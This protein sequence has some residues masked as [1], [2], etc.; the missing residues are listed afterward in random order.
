MKK[1]TRIVF[2]LSLMVLLSGSLNA[3]K[4]VLQP[5]GTQYAVWHDKSKPL[6]DVDP[7]NVKEMKNNWPAGVVKNNFERRKYKKTGNRSQFRTDP[8]VQRHMGTRQVEQGLSQNFDGMSR[9]EAGGA[10]PPDPS[11][12]VGNEY[13]FQMINLAFKIYDKNGT[14]V[15]GPAGNNT[16]FDGWDDG[17]PWDNTN[18]GDPIVL[19]DDQSDR[20]M[21]SHFSLPSFQGPYYILIAYSATS[22]PL[23]AYYRYAFQINSF[24]DYPKYG[25]W[26]DGIYMTTNSTSQNAVVFQRDSM[27]VGANAQMVTFSIPD[28]P[29][30]GFR[31]ALA[32]D[33]DGAFPPLGTPNY[34]LYYNDDAWGSYPNDHLR[35]WEFSTD[36]ANTSN[37]T[38]TLQN[39][40]LTDPFDTNFGSGWNNI[41]QPNSQKLDAITQAMMFKV[42]YRQMAGHETMLCN[43]VVDVD[44]SNHAGIRWYELRKDSTDWYIYQQGTY[45]PDDENRWMGSMAMD[46]HGN[47]AL[48]YSVSSSNTYPSLRFTGHTAG[49]PLGFMNVTETEIVTGSGAQSGTNRYGDYSQMGIDPYDDETFWFTSEYIPNGGNWRT[50]ISA[51]KFDPVVVADIDAGFMSFVGP[52]SSSSLTD[53]EAVTVKIANFGADTLVDVPV[54]LFHNN[55]LVA[56]DTISG[57]LY[58]GINQTFTFSNTVDL[59]ALGM[60]DL[61]ITLT[62][63][64]DTVTFNDSLLVS[65]EHPEPNYCDAG[66][67]TGYEFISKVIVDDFQNYSAGTQS[68]SLFLQDTVKVELGETHNIEVTIGNGYNS[69]Q[70]IVWFDWNQDLDFDDNGEKFIVGSG[71]GPVSTDFTVPSTAMLGN[72]RMRVRLHDA[73]SGA[74]NTPCG[75]SDYGEV[76]DYTVLITDPLSAE[77]IYADDVSFSVFPNPV[78]DRLSLSVEHLNYSGFAQLIND[79]GSEIA[80]KQL[81]ASSSN[82]KVEFDM[83]DLPAGLYFVRLRLSNNTILAVEKIVKL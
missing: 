73:S 36:W 11:G 78:N 27:L 30:G 1:I 13:F 61:L 35:I 56:N 5:D 6:R 39:T 17:Q 48:A 72:T 16:M 14:S 20:W 2:V 7:R 77:I 10:I 55:V 8:S 19:Y 53:Q 41:T 75:D 40:L 9:F 68:F 29:G 58:P 60:H 42:Q 74:N 49:A 4:V 24:P 62:Y 63:P 57:S 28:Y 54:N 21:V 47:I 66:G 38:L 31:S 32:A 25:I 79:E 43:Y 80:I 71:T 69:D 64:G 67:G 22:D 18:D 83:T 12:D 46:Q 34:L 51:F 33:C 59:S 23:G 50:R 82:Q 44:G 45:A 15:Y 37:S 70:V 52:A 26:P 81:H 3:Q 76:E 65:I